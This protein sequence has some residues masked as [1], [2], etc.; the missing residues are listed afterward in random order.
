M[1]EPAQP[2]RVHVTWGPDRD[3][4]ARLKTVLQTLG[5]Q[6]VYQDEIATLF[7]KDRPRADGARRV[8]VRG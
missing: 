5:V 7:T 1:A 8:S 2:L 3:E 4:N 6:P